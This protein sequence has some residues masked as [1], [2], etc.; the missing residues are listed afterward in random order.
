MVTSWINSTNLNY[1]IVTRD[2]HFALRG[3]PFQKWAENR[4]EEQIGQLPISDLYI[5]IMYLLINNVIGAVLIKSIVKTEM[6]IL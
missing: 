3:P 2:G 6:L 4:K 5:Y 1:T